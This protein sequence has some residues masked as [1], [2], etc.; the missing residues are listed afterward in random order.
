MNELI[1]RMGQI[2]LES[3]LGK[4]IYALVFNNNFKNIV[5]VGTWKGL[6]STYCILKALEDTKSYKTHL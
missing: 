2:N 3:N 5:D 1:G 6:G 4:Q